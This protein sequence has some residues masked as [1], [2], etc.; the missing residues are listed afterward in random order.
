MAC[1]A[2]DTS[3]LI[4]LESLLEIK[5]Y[6]QI[7]YFEYQDKIYLYFQ[8][9]FINVDNDRILNILSHYQKV[10]RRLNY[11]NSSESINET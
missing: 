6:I 10:N 1:V 5:G 4:K 7:V 2:D 3:V 11:Q 9:Q 8:I